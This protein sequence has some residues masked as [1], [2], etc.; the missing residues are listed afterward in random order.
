MNIFLCIFSTYAKKT[1][2]K[3]DLS[4]ISLLILCLRA[5]ILIQ[6]YA[7]PA[8]GAPFHE[9]LSAVDS[10]APQMQPPSLL[11]FLQNH[12]CFFIDRLES[13]NRGIYVIL[14]FNDISSKII[15]H[16]HSIILSKF[17]QNQMQR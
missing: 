16:I 8:L 10:D 2:T 12:Y 13:L 7:F 4:Y 9:R 5:L 17:L 14:I 6:S 1:R 15:P 3:S 11:A